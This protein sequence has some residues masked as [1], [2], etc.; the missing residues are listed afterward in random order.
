MG[1]LDT[2]QLEEL[3]SRV[4]RRNRILAAI[5]VSAVVLFGAFVVTL[6]V[7]SPRLPSMHWYDAI[8]PGVSI[9]ATP[10]LVHM[11]RRYDRELLEGYAKPRLPSNI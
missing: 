7:M 3:R 1:R 5:F 4:R 10:G 8:L 2:P 9:L 11:W 6:I